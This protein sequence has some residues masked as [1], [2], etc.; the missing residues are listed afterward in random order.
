M[1]DA[2]DENDRFG[3]LKMWFGA[4]KHKAEVGVIVEAKS[5]EILF[6]ELL[7]TRCIFFAA[8]GWENVLT[9]LSDAEKYAIDT[10]VGIIDAD[11]KRIRGFTLP[12]NLFLTD[13]HDVEMMLAHSEAWNNVLNHFCDREKLQNFEQRTNTSILSFLLAL[14]KPI[15]IL[16]FLNTRDDLKFIFKIQKAGKYDYIKYKDFV[17]ANSMALNSNDLLKTVENK[18]NLPNFFKSNPKYVVEYQRLLDENLDVTEW[19]NG[20]DLLNILSISLEKVIANK[21][22][23][24]TVSSEKLEESLVIAYRLSDFQQT[25]LYSDLQKWQS[26]HVNTQLLQ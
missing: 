14:I 15:G 16:R 24:N 18:S 20:H 12:E 10:V 6:R 21:S 25:T 19:G 23:S 17:D 11:F 9:M 4:R 13:Y 3:E 7:H 5:D 22:S 2:I 1:Y 8:Q 26:N